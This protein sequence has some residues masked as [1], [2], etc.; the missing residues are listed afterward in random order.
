VVLPLMDGDELFGIF[1]ILSSRPNAFGQTDL[2]NLQVLTDRIVESRRQN[3]ETTATVPRKE[4]GSFMHELD[5]VVPQKKSRSSES[6]SGGLH[7]ERI[8]RRGDIRTAMLGVLVIASAVLLGTMVGW[9]LGWQKATLGLRTSLPHHRV[10]SPSKTRRTDNIVIPGEEP[11][12]S[13]AGTDECGQSEAAGSPARPPSGGLTVCQDGRV[14][15]RLP[16]SVPSP[17][18]APRTAQRPPG[19]EADPTRR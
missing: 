2:D 6:D 4:S 17:T 10:N 16:P 15:F 7:R 8:S 14:I 12:P 3:W 18:R 13:S 1:E 11:R 5:E 9:R 19:L